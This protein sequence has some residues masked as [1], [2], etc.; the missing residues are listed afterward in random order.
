MQRMIYFFPTQNECKQAITFKEFKLDAWRG[1]EQ[2]C[3]PNRMQST[4]GILLAREEGEVGKKA[5]DLSFK[6]PK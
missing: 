3:L 2:A 1:H 4:K 5:P 6:P